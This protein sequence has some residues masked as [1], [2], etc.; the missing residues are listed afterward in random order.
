ME[1]SGVECLACAWPVLLRGGHPAGGSGGG[2]A[3]RGAASPI[4]P[5]R[6]AAT[7]RGGSGGA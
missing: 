6:E 1:W 4:A 7:R 3:P 5:F 2:V